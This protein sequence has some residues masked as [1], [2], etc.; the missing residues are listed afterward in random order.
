MIISKI[1]LGSKTPANLLLVDSLF[2]SMGP[3][4]TTVDHN[5]ESALQKRAQDLAKKYVI[6]EVTLGGKS[7]TMGDIILMASA[8]YDGYLEALNTRR[9]S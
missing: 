5:E 2:D 3:A 6:K 4:D 9:K 8:Y 7:Y 1:R